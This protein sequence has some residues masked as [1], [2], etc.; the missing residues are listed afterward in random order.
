MASFRGSRVAVKR[1]H[2]SRVTEKG[3]RNFVAEAK[4]MAGLQKEGGV[5]HANVLQMLHVSWKEEV[6]MV[7]GFLPLL[8]RSSCSLATDLL[9]FRKLGYRDY[10]VSDSLSPKIRALTTRF[11]VHSVPKSEL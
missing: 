11:W 2:A 9:L 1:T 8:F 10:P 5:S 4:L 6:M 3:V 7:S